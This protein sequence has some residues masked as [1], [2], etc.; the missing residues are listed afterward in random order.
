M[1]HSS[2]DIEE[3][4]G[5]THPPLQQAAGGGGGGVSDSAALLPGRSIGGRRIS[6]SCAVDD[7]A[8]NGGAN[9]AFR[10]RRRVSRW[11]LALTAGLAVAALVSCAA[12]SVALSARRTAA[13]AAASSSLASF[14]RGA[15]GG[16]AAAAA[17]LQRRPVRRVA[18]G[19]CSAYDLRPQEV[20]TAGV[21]PAAPDAWIWVGDFAYFDDPVVSH[22]GGGCWW[23]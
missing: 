13:A 16:D 17:S 10:T 8:S 21:I 9:G 22:L 6:S 1:K 4:P 14:D 3:D 2:F 18:F 11:L 20:W 23:R 7:A 15:D 19:S 5:A 12:L